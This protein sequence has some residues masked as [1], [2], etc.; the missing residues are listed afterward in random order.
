MYMGHAIKS[1]IRSIREVPLIPDA[2]TTSLKGRDAKMEEVARTEVV[3]HNECQNEV[4]T[5]AR[6]C[7]HYAMCKID[8]FGSGVCA[9]GLTNI[10]SVF[11]PKAE[12]TFMQRLWK[13]QFPVTEKCV[14]IADSC[15]LCGKC[16]YQCYFR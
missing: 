16:D 12:W 14:E 4:L 6:N 3:Q 10:M 5:I 15:S 1:H 2:A 11:I 9:S 7:R 13:I 8:F